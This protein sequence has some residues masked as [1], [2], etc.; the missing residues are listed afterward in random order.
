MQTRLTVRIAAIACVLI[1]V[2]LVFEAPQARATNPTIPT[3]ANMALASQGA[4]AS[5][6]SE[7]TGYEASKA[8][9]GSTG[10]SWISATSTATFTVAFAAKYYIL[11]VHV[12][13]A[14][15]AGADPIT[16]VAQPDIDFYADA[17]GTGTWTLVKS[18]RGN[19][20]LDLVVSFGT[21]TSAKQL[22]AAFLTP[23]THTHE[24]TTTRR[25]CI[26]Y[27]FD[28]YTGRRG[29]C[30]AYDTQVITTTYTD[31]HPP[32]VREFEAWGNVY[33]RDGDGLSN[34]Y[35]ESMIY[36]QDASVSGLPMAIPNNGN[37]V[38]V[39]SLDRPLWSG[40]A[41]RA[42]LDLEV[43]HASPGD[44]VV[45]LGSWDGAAW[46]DRL[47]WVPGT[48]AYGSI[49]DTV[50]ITTTWQ[51]LDT[52][53]ERHFDDLNGV[54]Y[55][56]YKTH[57]VTHTS[58]STY[59]SRAVAAETGETLVLSS[60]LVP[61]TYVTSAS[62]TIWHVRIDLTD[63]TLDSVESGAGFRA[64]GLTVSELHSRGSWRILVRDWNPGAAGGTLRSASIR[65]E[66]KTDSYRADT[67]GDG[68]YN[69]GAEVQMKTFPVALDTDFDGLTDVYEMSPQPLVLTVDGVTST[70]Y[71][72]TDPTK[73]D[74]DG[75]GLNDGEER[76]LGA[77][78]VVTD[79]TNP[80]TDGDGL[81][82]G[83]TVN[84]HPG[85]LSYNC[86]ATRSDTDG[87]TFSDL[88]E[89]TPR[90]LTLT[91]N[92]APVTRSITTLPYSADSDGDGLKDNEEWYGTSVYGVKTDPSVAD[93]DG[94][95]LAD[96]QE[97]YMKEVAMPTRKPIG[98]Y[99][100]VPLSIRIAGPVEKATISYGLSTIDVSNFYLRLYQG[101]N[102]I[103][104]RNHAGSGLFNFSSMDLPASMWGTGTYTLEASSWTSGG[105]LEK[106]SVLF[107]LR[108]SPIS[109]DTDGDGLNDLEETTAGQDGWITDPNLADSDGDTLSDFYEVNVLGTNPL[110]ADTDG[111][112]ARDNVD[113]D[114]L[115]NLVVQVR[116]N[117]IYH[118]ASPW[119]TPELVGV[120]R[121]NDAYAWVTEHR[122]ATE[123]SYTS[124][125]CPPL[126]P[127]TQYAT[128]AFYMTYY[129][130][131]PDDVPWATI[132]ITAW[133]I[134]PGRGDDILVDTSVNYQVNSGWTGYTTCN[135][136][137]WVSYEVSTYPL[138]KAKTL[139]ITDGQV[140]VR[141][142]AGQTRMAA[143]DR[144][145]VFTLNVNSAW[146]PLASGINTILVP[147]SVFLDSKLKADFSAGSYY[148]LSDAP[149]YGDD[150]SKA[151]VS[152]GVAGVVATTLSADQANDVL[153]RLLMNASGGWAHSYVD[154]TN[155]AVVANLPLDVV[156]I[157]PWSGVTN[158]PFGAMPQDFWSKVGS[159]ATTLV[160]ALVYVGQLIYK[161]LVALGT[162]LVDLAQAI[163]EWGMKALGAVWNAAVSVA[164]KASQLLSTVVSWIIQ[165]ATQAFQTAIQGLLSL[166]KALLDFTIG[167]IVGL[168][169]LAVASAEISV[170]LLTTIA[171][172]VFDLA[173][174]IA[175]IP[176]AIRVA[177]A[178]IA[179]MTMGVGFVAMKAIAKLTGE[180]IVRTLSLMAI[181]LVAE[182]LIAETMESFG[183]VETSTV[184]FFK[185]VGIVVSTLAGIGKAALSAYKIYRDN[186]IL[187]RTPWWR[188]LGFG[189]SIVSLLLVLGAGMFN[190]SGRQLFM[191]DLLGIALGFGGLL[192]YW[193]ESLNAPNQV[194]DAL[195]SVG[196][197]VEKVVVYCT[198]PLAFARV[199]DHG[200]TIPG[201]G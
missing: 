148:P 18:V 103:V 142:A 155:Q 102:S 12:H 27:A 33:D 127:T 126:I 158:G 17:E 26:E 195:S 176:M 74:T 186:I 190:L 125:A 83:Y 183:W 7:I 64:P 85:E 177:E 5:A 50:S 24:K 107:T 185:G 151:D 79:P 73:A 188:W 191:A 144:F 189:M 109:S 106:F 47:V 14:S 140:T 163:A 25:V 66:E 152:G 181:S 44:L 128:S 4:M 135:G 197:T 28:E 13:M 8:I 61:S 71:R 147:R 99:L 113:L 115:H 81:W 138:A 153:N 164:E 179:I 46:Q 196:A 45:A 6:S 65:M 199:I 119:C 93:T 133:A 10:T 136:N 166:V 104:V 30:L 131:V 75:D 173:Q 162:F 19:A 69:D 84:G 89:I 21:T 192:I 112:G 3:D 156:K 117:K 184:E 122:M 31:T 145:F 121:V 110:L 129:A 118:G 51:S 97:R 38:L 116:I 161:G 86:N 95:G 123:D 36:R 154:I 172:Y 20:N 100:S 37:D 198:L 2:A 201:Y 149:L 16:S 57:W 134:N 167:N 82:D 29:A 43:D 92:G 9:D 94:D 70:V 78:R 146:S 200:R 80:D 157:L 114:P 55:C 77:D 48:Y 39:F 120:V 67:D 76:S 54:F 174:M 42:F 193:T 41:T 72:T 182:Y 159:A 194:M 11:E 62:S 143:A 141:S 15:I 23:V 180:F 165:L 111:D 175:L 40:I 91:I 130:D 56:V 160:N 68:A 34:G 98:T 168:V 87:D 32:Q 108:T 169:K 49:W 132:R 139:L 35:E 170:S 58:T 52:Y 124:W 96:G 187:K 88:I 137:S 150:L 171:N 1:M 105:I 63:A 22:R 60:D 59:P 53:C 101:A 178:A 90:S